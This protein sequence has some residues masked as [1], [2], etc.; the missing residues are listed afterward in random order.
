MAPQFYRII[1][2][3]ADTGFKIRGETKEQLFETAGLAFFDIMWSI[4]H[5]K[6]SQPEIIEVTGIDL[7]EL[8]VNFLQLLTLKFA[9]R[10]G[11]NCLMITR[12]LNFS[13]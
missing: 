6:E 10:H 1:E 11:C 7:K 8:L 3:T 13:G 12:T 4:G 5:P 2:H 9:P